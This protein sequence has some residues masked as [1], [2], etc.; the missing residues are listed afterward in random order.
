MR[1]KRWMIYGA[2]GYTG[3]LLAAAARQA[4]L[5]PV[6]AGRDAAKLQ[7]VAAPLALETRVF[8][9]DDAESVAAQL[10]GFGLLLNTAGPFATT[11]ETALA[12][13]LASG[14]HYL[15]ITGEIDVFEHVHAQDGAARRAGIIACPGVG[16]DVIP[17]DCMAATLKAALPDATALA[18]GFHTRSSSSPG[19]AKT[20]IA[21]MAKGGRIRRNSRI[22]AV[23]LAYR[24]REVD[25]GQ[26]PRTLVTVP[27]GDVSTAFFT[28][29]I[30]NIET[31]M[32]IPPA[33]LRQLK[34]LDTGRW[35]LNL[36]AVQ[37]LLERQVE[38]RVRGPEAAE[39]TGTPAWIW[40]EVRN[41][42]GEV[43]SGRLQVA[44]GY[45]VTVH[46]ALGVV[47]KLLSQPHPP[48]AYTPAQLMG[49]DYITRLPGSGEFL[50]RRE[51]PAAPVEPAA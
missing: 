45:D 37:R 32:A 16:F 33:R 43:C 8:A 49:K 30:G 4:G 12:A 48:G 51:A 27:W 41:A 50:L 42:R 46:G 31:Y 17:T 40:G 25:F 2:T 15:D 20:A 9:L 24:H 10:K 21:G 47:E 28:T 18:L 14:C 35:L 29:G 34:W 11:A 38:K 5:E 3:R 22:E 36:P 6:L 26:G 23:P 19:T 7:A 44:N 39:R 13:C 1:I